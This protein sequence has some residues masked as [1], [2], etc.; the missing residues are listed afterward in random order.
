VNRVGPK[1]V[2]ES[3]AH[4]PWA[5]L[6][7][8]TLLSGLMGFAVL[9][10]Q[11]YDLFEFIKALADPQRGI[12]RPEAVLLVG[13][14]IVCVGVFVARRLREA[15]V[16]AALT[17]TLDVEMRALRDLAMQDP[18][19]SL[20]NRRALLLALDA[21]LQNPPREGQTH[22]F[23]MLDLNGFKGIND[24][25][26]HTAGDRVLQVVVDRFLGAAREGDLLARL[27]GDEFAVLACNVDPEAV[28]AIGNRFIAALRH[29]VQTEDCTRAVGV[30]VGGVLIPR[31]GDTVEKVLRHADVAMYQAKA[32]RAASPVLFDA[33]AA[34]AADMPVKA[35]G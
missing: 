29:D 18:L 22:A 7:D 16:D 34:V 25:Y 9:M 14:A 5:S 2:A 12:S 24:V 4:H 15:R 20:P 6:W 21:A 8:F 11:R 35:A 23:F 26:G 13:L 28:G 32:T 27:G 17:P 19:T 31:D 3:I 1:L 10:A 33:A 30:A